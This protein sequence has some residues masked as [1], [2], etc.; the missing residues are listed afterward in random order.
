MSDGQ[1]RVLSDA[2]KTLTTLLH[3]HA[4]TLDARGDGK[5]TH[6]PVSAETMGS[7]VIQAMESLM[8]SI[9]PAAAS[10]DPAASLNGHMW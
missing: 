5:C 7:Y 4:V 2:E 6:S 10:G 9:D 3:S 1:E 8:G